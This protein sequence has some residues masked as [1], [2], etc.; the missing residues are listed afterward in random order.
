ML[1]VLLFGFT[2]VY[3]L[4]I[5]GLR[6][7][8]KRKNKETV[9][10][11][12]QVEEY[13]DIIV[14]TKESAG[15]REYSIPGGKISI[16]T[17][18]HADLNL[19]NPEEHTET[20]NS[21][22]YQSS[23]AQKEANAFVIEITEGGVFFRSPSGCLVNGVEVKEKKLVPGS[24]IVWG[25]RRIIFKGTHKLTIY[26]KEKPDFF[27]VYHIPVLLT[28]LTFSLVFSQ[29]ELW[30]P[31][32]LGRGEIEKK[33]REPALE[34][35][36]P[37]ENSLAPSEGLR[38]YSRPYEAHTLSRPNMVKPGETP[39][40]F[41]ADIMCIHA[42]PDDETIDFGGFIANASRDGK[43]IVTILFTD[44]ESGVV[45]SDFPIKNISP[46]KLASIRVRET[47]RA[48]SNLGVEEYV[49]LGL[50]NHPYNSNTH[51][52]SKEEV[53]KDWGGEEE[54]I[55]TLEELISSYSPSIVLSPDYDLEAHEHFEHKTV[56]YLTKK[57]LE[58]LFDKGESSVK[59]HLIAGDHLKEEQDRAVE[60]ISGIQFAEEGLSPM[61]I[62]SQA[63]Q[64][65]HTQK[66]A[67][68]IALER[69]LELKQECYKIGFWDH[70]TRIEEYFVSND[71]NR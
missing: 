16:G 52:L 6:R 37:S 31:T 19:N 28:L 70:S 22:H 15:P 5:T 18:R 45:R 26:P 34:I 4:V 57:V 68:I 71:Q 25:S 51:V 54:L 59:G 47:E 69:T 29:Q 46:K 20:A 2:G 8:Y 10:S 21:S 42:H 24:K 48:L 60:C 61:S 12:P 14:F 1:E 56:G 32:T 64:Q 41:D 3:L 55:K 39:E 30:S 62:K 53:L 33:G 35:V 58:N 65:Y 43:K 44:G 27:P 50:K 40:F 9:A 66:D 63:L 17:T 23:S 13:I 38:E 7:Y 36:L 11:N 67:S 49:R